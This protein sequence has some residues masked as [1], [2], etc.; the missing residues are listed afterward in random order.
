M[1]IQ[2]T[3]EWR[4]DR[5]GHVTASRIA[6]LMARTRSGWGASRVNYMAELIAE[7]LTGQPADSYTS[8]A[9]ARGTETEPLARDAYAF[10]SGHAVEQVGFIKHSAIACSGCSPDGLV[11]ADGL[12]EIKC[13]NTAVPAKYILQMQ[14]QMAVTG[15]LW[16]DFVSFDARLPE[17]MRLFHQ[18]VM[19]DGPQI[20]ELE[21]AVLEFLAELADKV[22]ALRARYDSADRVA[23]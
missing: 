4:R 5:C 20:A 12:V 16:C 21:A 19:R 23:A 2:G 1:S 3:D 22:E 8:A 11:G 13:P 18:R 15:R 6:D 7:R 14:W 17:S 10:Y 9:M